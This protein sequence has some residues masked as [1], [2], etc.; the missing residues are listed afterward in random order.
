MGRISCQG[1]RGEVRKVSITRRSGEEEEMDGS[2][3]I[4]SAALRTRWT[5]CGMKLEE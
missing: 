4:V 3:G 5:A 2:E 1:R